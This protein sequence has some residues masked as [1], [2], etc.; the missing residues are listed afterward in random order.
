MRRL[1]P[2]AAASDS[3][4]PGGAGGDEGIPRGGRRAG[5]PPA[6]VVKLVLAM[7]GSLLSA[8]LRAFVGAIFAS[9]QTRLH[10]PVED[11]RPA[12]KRRR[13][14]FFEGY[15]LHA[16]TWCGQNDRQSLERLAR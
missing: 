13:C 6:F 7:D 12:P 5:W 2:A 16:D 4:S 10:L 11:E 3:A 9:A 14:A 15:S 1:R 8:A